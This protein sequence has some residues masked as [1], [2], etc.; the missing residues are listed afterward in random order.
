MT[1]ADVFEIVKENIL[2][3]LPDVSEEEIQI[4]GSMKDLGANSIDRAD[5]VVGSM[6]KLGLKIPL[7]EFGQLKNIQELVDLLYER[8][9][10]NG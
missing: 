2:D 5:I 10:S 6:E 9:V 8:K 7:V 3:I 1:K 4:E